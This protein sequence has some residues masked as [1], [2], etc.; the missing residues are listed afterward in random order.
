MSPRANRD[1]SAEYAARKARAQAQGYTGYS[2][3]GG[4]RRAREVGVP[5]PTDPRAPV[6]R[7]RVQAIQLAGGRLAAT[8]GMAGVRRELERA[9]RA[10][11]LVAIRATMQTGAGGPIRTR[12][13]DKEGSLLGAIAAGVPVTPSGVNAGAVPVPPSSAP[14]LPAGARMPAGTVQ[15][16]SLPPGGA[17]GVDPGLVLRLIDAYEDAG[18]SEWEWLGDLFDDSYG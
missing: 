14:K 7:A 12:T 18:A 2:G 17:R 8:S 3:G 6:I 16:F 15:I 13:V 4:Q 9:D 1:Y 10:G 5:L 11:D